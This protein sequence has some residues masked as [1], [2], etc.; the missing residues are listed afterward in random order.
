MK[1]TLALLALPLATLGTQQ[2]AAAAPVRDWRRVA[3]EPDRDRIRNWRDTWLKALAK[4]SPGH[5]DAI[6]AAGATL[7]PDAALAEPSPPPNHYRCRL[8]KLGALTPAN[9]DFSLSPTV[10]CR[11]TTD[12]GQL[13]FSVLEGPQ[14]PNGL[15]YS[16]RGR[17]LIFLGA[18]ILSDERKSMRYGADTERNLAGVVERIGANRWRLV[19][20]SPRW[21]TMLEVIDMVPEG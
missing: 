15:L 5:A 12:E 8:F 20:P 9:P 6:A 19:L 21:E 16:D 10:A 17:R 4:G 13:R 1:W 3:S 7:Q 14:R 2:A 11:V 18:M